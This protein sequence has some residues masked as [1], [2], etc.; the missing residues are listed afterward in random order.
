MLKMCYGIT[1]NTL[2]N[3]TSIDYRGVGYRVG[4]VSEY[5]VPTLGRVFTLFLWI[6]VTQAVKKINIGKNLT[7]YIDPPFPYLIKSIFPI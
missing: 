4:Q 7:C 1:L 2:S 6:V 3:K 5:P